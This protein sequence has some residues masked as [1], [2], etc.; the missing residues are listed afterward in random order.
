MTILFIVSE[1]T[2]T[3]IGIIVGI[4]VFA[5]CGALYLFYGKMDETAREEFCAFFKKW[6]AKRHDKKQLKLHGS[7][8]I[9]EETRSK[10]D[11]VD[12]EINRY[13]EETNALMHEII[14]INFLEDE[15]D[16]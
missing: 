12:L 8:G 16:H 4:V 15:L 6:Q 10:L 5:V 7:I 2:F 1:K 3:I 11:D 9:E 14:D 13:C